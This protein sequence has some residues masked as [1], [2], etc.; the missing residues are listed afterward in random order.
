MGAEGL[1]EWV[2]IPGA[3]SQ[4]ISREM[5]LQKFWRDWVE[6]SLWAGHEPLGS[7]IPSTLDPGCHLFLPSSFQKFYGKPTGLFISPPS[8]IPILFTST[9]HY[10]LS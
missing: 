10:T 2:P 3:V 1:E 5:F 9:K 7:A 8:T 6:R 4:M